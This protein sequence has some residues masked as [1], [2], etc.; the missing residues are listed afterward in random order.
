MGPLVLYDGVCGL[1]NGTVQWLLDH[2]QAGK[3]QFAP[4]QGE[5][6]AAL[7]ARHPEIPVDLDSVILVE[8]ENG[9][10]RLFWRSTAILRLAAYLGLPWSIASI[11]GF[12]PQILT[13]LPYRLIAAL[14]YRLFGKL[15]AC[16]LPRPEERARFLP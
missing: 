13:D 5:T 2:D 10:E 4:L 12:L 14:R 3:L 9:E 15:D 8:R 1:C 16:R 11:F 6:T 7:R